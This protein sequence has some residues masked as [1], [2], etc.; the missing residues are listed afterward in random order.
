MSATIQPMP[1]T[2]SADP[3]VSGEPT[4]I[5]ATATVPETNAIEMALARISAMCRLRGLP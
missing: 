5:V 1:H 2:A 4:S 3:N